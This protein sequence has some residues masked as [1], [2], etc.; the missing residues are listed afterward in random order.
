MMRWILLLAVAGFAASQKVQLW[1]CVDDLVYNTRNCNTLIDPTG[2][3]VTAHDAGVNQT[4]IQDEWCWAASIEMAARYWGYYLPQTQ[5]VET[6]WGKITD[7]PGSPAQIIAATN[8]VYV[9][10][11]GK[12]FRLTSLILPT[13]T[14]VSASLAANYPVLV[15][16]LGHMTVILG[17]NITFFKNQFG[18][19]VSSQVN[20]V[21]IWDPWPGNGLRDMSPIE[22]QSAFLALSVGATPETISAGLNRLGIQKANETKV[23]DLLGRLPEKSPREALIYRR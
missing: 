22:F 19:V 20:E 16:S 14:D 11:R 23:F 17:L 13:W 7:M 6:T 15:G 9:D 2:L 10:T 5:I 18:Q 1:N 4:Q 8:R 12:A 3:E 21:A